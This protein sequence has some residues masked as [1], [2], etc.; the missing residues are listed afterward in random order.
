MCSSSGRRMQR[1]RTIDHRFA[2]GNSPAH[3]RISAERPGQ[4]ITHQ[5]QLADVGVQRLH[6]GHR[7]GMAVRPEYAGSAFQKLPPPGRD[8]VQVNVKLLRQLGQGPLFLTAA[9]ATFALKAGL[10]FRRVGS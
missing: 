2:L 1:V 9:K 5:R 4:K 8:L 10:W 3:S 6:I 7:L